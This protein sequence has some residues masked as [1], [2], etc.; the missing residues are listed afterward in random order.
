VLDP[1]QRS[2]SILTV[3]LAADLVV[4]LAAAPGAPFDLVIAIAV[5]LAS[6]L[7]STESLCFGPRL[8]L[9]QKALVLAFARRF[10]PIAT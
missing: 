5:A 7:P 1:R 6:V 8:C 9:Q 3:N 4:A 10:H 2:R